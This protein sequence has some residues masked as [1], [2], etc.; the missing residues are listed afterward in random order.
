MTN[1]L[2]EIFELIEKYNDLVSYA[3]SNG[4]DPQNAR[5]I[6]QSV[7]ETFT[8]LTNVVSEFE[9]SYGLKFKSSESI[10]V[11][12]G[13]YQKLN[14]G[15]TSELTSKTKGFINE[16]IQISDKRIEIQKLSEDII[17]F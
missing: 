17:N 7:S 11:Y 9:K 13:K 10:Q 12:A 6:F 5:S 4:G 14:D 1:S 16:N 3:Q 15:F 8:Q 2:A